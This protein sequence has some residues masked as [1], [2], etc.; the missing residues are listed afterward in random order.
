MQL[1]LTIVLRLG[2]EPEPFA[3]GQCRIALKPGHAA[4]KQ[5][6]GLSDRT[7]ANFPDCPAAVEAWC[8]GRAVGGH[9]KHQELQ[10]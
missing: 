6:H 2:L 5:L 1:T 9:V 10:H 8:P 7:S 4:V 3:L